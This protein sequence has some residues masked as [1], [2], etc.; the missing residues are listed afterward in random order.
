MSEDCDE[1]N[2]SQ[3]GVAFLLAQLGAHA[4]ARFADRVAELDLTPAQ[5]GLLRMIAVS[6][7]LSQQT[8]AARLGTPPSRFVVLVDTLQGRNL[9]ER[10]RGSPDR[11]SYALHLT[12]DGE[13]LMGEMGAVG[14]AHEGDLCAALTASERSALRGMLARIAE[15]QGLTPGVHPGYRRPAG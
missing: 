11:R 10:R 6:P 15:Q 13:R 1:P 2:Q 9:V 3:G 7:G 4:A 8:Y 14:M 12:G 5:A